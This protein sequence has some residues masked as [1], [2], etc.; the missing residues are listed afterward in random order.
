MFLLELLWKYINN[1]FIC[2]IFYLSIEI[3]IY[4]AKKAQ[5]KIRRIFKKGGAYAKA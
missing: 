1:L 4:M 2:K 3:R 5:N